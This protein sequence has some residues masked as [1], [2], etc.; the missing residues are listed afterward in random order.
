MPD[1]I[2]FSGSGRVV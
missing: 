1:W 2:R